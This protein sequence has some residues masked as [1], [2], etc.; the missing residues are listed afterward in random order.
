MKK[1]IL[2]IGHSA[3][4]NA[5]ARILSER[6]EVFVA[7]GNDGIKEFATVVDIR[8]NNIVELLN[9]ALEHDI[10]FTICASEAS[11][12]LNIAEL[13]NDNGL[14]IFAPTA[15]SAQFTISRATAKKM[16]YK[17]RL[18]T[19]RFAVFEKKNL[20][21]DYIKNADMPVVIKT[22]GNKDKNSTMVCPSSNIAKSFIEDCFFGGETKVI[23]ED[24]VYGT[25]FSFY[26]ITDGYKALPLGSVKDYK[27]SLDGDGGVLTEG[28][29]ACS[30]FTKLTYDH[31]D[32][33][34]NEIVY[35][36][37]NYLSEGQKA[38]MGIIGFDG[39]LTPEGDVAITE[40]SS[41]LKDHDA[42]GV[43]ALLDDDIFEL[44]HACV[45]GSFSD[46][47]DILNF[48]DDYAVSC[49]L[50]SGHSKNDVIQGLDEVQDDTLIGHINTKQNEYTE[51]ETLGDRTVV[52]TTIAKTI[53]RATLNLYEEIDNIEFKGKYYRK[54]LCAVQD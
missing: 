17:L 39:I 15:D 52:I 12:K 43:L 26:V 36:V 38:Y 19:P 37:I 1:S 42:Q 3:R 51:F 30:P 47:Y 44:M 41:F 34:M 10:F 13:F 11:I 49:V 6:F 21:L 28:M 31:E 53:S 50:S 7:S 4:E 27:F 18:P 25:N 20:A 14:M 46:E 54:D 48:K 29:G 9:F 32:Y 23:I 22:D 8:E 45:I 40:C 5:L 24:Y 33:I 35:P 16:F 2:I